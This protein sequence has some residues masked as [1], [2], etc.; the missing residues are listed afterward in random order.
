[1]VNTPTCHRWIM[2]MALLFLALACP[3][4]ANPMDV[5][6]NSVYDEDVLV[7]PQFPTLLPRVFISGGNSTLI[8]ISAATSLLVSTIAIVGLVLGAIY[9]FGALFN[10]AIRSGYG[11]V[12]GLFGPGFY[13]PQGYNGFYNPNFYQNQQQAQTYSYEPY[14][15]LG[16][17]SSERQN[18]QSRFQSHPS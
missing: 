7:T 13:G 1:M 11:G 9:V 15:K 3:T 16:T 6:D 18:V 14:S 4:G 12:G 8:P 5:V 2:W 10:P 17:Y